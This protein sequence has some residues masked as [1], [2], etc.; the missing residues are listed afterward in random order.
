MKCAIAPIKPQRDIIWGSQSEFVSKLVF[1][2]PF[3]CIKC[4]PKTEVTSEIV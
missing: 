4:G 3:D 2:P 1:F